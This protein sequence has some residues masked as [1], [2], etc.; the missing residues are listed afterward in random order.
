[1]GG[2]GAAKTI[3]HANALT[4]FGVMRQEYWFK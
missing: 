4:A 3:I 1:M 2:G